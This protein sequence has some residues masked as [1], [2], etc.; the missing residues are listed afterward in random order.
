MTPRRDLADLVAG[1]ADPLQPARHRRRRL[2]LDDQVDGAHVDAELEAAGGD[3]AR[4]PAGLEVVLDERALL[5]GHRAVVGPGDQRLGAVADSAGLGHASAPAACDGRQVDGLEPGR[6]SA[7]I[8]LSRAVRRSARRRELANTMVE[9]CCS[10]RSTMRSS[11]CG[12]IEAGGSRPRR[13]ADRTSPS[14]RRARS[15]PRPARRP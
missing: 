11:T 6:R 1:A 12:Q 9:R 14:A 4:Q 7:A 8:S 3:D 5:L 13:G 15:C 2:D 10:I